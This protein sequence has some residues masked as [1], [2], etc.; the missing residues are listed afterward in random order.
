MPRR[1]GK[2]ALHTRV[3]Q[4]K[5]KASRA[6]RKAELER[7]IYASTHWCGCDKVHPRCA[8]YLELLEQEKDDES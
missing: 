3:V 8:E 1:T 6:S 7:D 2:E 4:R 5:D